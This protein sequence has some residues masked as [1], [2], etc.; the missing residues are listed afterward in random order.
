MAYSNLIDRNLQKAFKMA[1]DLAILATFRK[2]TSTDFDFD[3]AT[4]AVILDTTAVAKIL[5]MKTEK[6]NS[7]TV[8]KEFMVIAKD[9]GDLTLFDGVD[10][11]GKTW[12]LGAP[13]KSNGFVYVLQAYG[14]PT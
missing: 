1:K 2:K 6:L 9:I 3:A 10:F 14:A 5:I 12:R 11:E 8:R 7:E 4:D 13:I